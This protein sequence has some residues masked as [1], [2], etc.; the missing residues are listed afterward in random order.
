LL[1]ILEDKGIRAILHSPTECNLEGKQLVAGYLRAAGALGVT[2]LGE[3]AVTGFDVGPRGVERVSTAR[4][5]IRPG[6]VGDAAGA[7]SGVVAELLGTGLPVVPTRHQLLITEP[8][9]GIT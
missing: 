6:G 9:P 8:I 3:T 4:G 2:V 1:P 5:P 7:W